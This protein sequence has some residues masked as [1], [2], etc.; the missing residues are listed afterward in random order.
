MFPLRAMST[1]SKLWERHVIGQQNSPIYI[2]EKNL[3]G[4]ID[5]VTTINVHPGLYYS[6]VAW[7]RNNI[8]QGNS[9]NKLQ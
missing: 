9:W 4:D 7:F 5:I 1:V 2:Y 8:D 3:D 6:E